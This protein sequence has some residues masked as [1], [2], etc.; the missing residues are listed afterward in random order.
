MITVLKKAD[1]HT[2]LALLGSIA[3]A[4]PVMS[5]KGVAVAQPA[6][7]ICQPPKAGEYLLL[8]VSPTL[9]SQEQVRRALPGK[10]DA[11]ACR[12][13]ND[14]VTRIGGFT[15]IE[16]ASS[17]QQYIKD[18]VGLPA[19]VAQGPRESTT[20]PTPETPQP[21]ST[22]SP[23]PTYTPQS[24]GT[25]YAVLVDYFNQ[26]EVANQVQQLLGRDVG[27]VSYGQ[28][29]YLLAI[30][31]ASSNTA[32]ITLRKLSDRGLFTML[33]DSRKVTLLRSRV[34]MD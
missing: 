1:V 29:P 32:A 20:S 23:T 13:F 8:V 33:V 19:Y 7:R 24:L 31:T 15:K 30:H 28:R 25:G 11:T 34:L 4:V 9:K 17:W 5:F 2:V 26:P 22:S 18:V 21:R 12:Y 6:A 16:D 27:L 10:I 3:L 14:T